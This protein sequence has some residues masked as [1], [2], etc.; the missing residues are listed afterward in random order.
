MLCNCR[1]SLGARQEI[2]DYRSDLVRVRLEGEVAGVEEAHVS[3]WNVTLERLGALR[4]EKRIVFAPGCQKR[5]LVLAKI[6]LEF[7]IQ[8][9]V[10]LVVTEEV[11]LHFICT[12]TSQIEIVEIL[13]IRRHRRLIENAM[14]ILPARCIRSKEGA[15]RLS[16]RLRRVLPVS[17]DRSPALTETFFVGIA[18]LRDDGRDPVGLAGS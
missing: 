9:D 16:V 12:G 8:R 7:G 3:V 6:E 11:E 10:A 14:R 4:Q 18:I 5:R 1:A 2:A 13:T 17:F 15:E